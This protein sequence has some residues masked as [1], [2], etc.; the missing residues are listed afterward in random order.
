MKPY[1]IF[2][3]LFLLAA[4]S[5]GAS[6]APSGAGANA[7]STAAGQ[8]SATAAGNAPGNPC[9]VITVAD[10]AG[11]FT[12]P[13]HR[14]LDY[15]GKDKCIYNSGSGA[16]LTIGT[17]KDDDRKSAWDIYRKL[18]VPLAGLGDD[19]LQNPDGATIMAAKGDIDCT[20]ELRGI[21]D[22]SA[23]ATITTDRGE[24]LA[25]KLGALCNKVFAAY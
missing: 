14:R 4:C 1:P 13:A 12:A 5:Q 6:T 21:G 17:L 24:S 8:T 18:M 7:A 2:A 20:A 19:A 25:K 23:E 22:S 16:A 10:V 9:D 11:I 3:S 15:W